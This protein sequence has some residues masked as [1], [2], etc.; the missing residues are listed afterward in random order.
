MW[1]WCDN[2]A[3]KD[4]YC[5]KRTNQAVIYSYFIHGNFSFLQKEHCDN[6]GRLA[7]NKA[8]EYLKFKWFIAPFF[9]LYL[10]TYAIFKWVWLFTIALLQRRGVGLL[11]CGCRCE[12]QWKNSTLC[13]GLTVWLWA[14]TWKMHPS[15]FHPPDYIT[16]PKESIWP[17][18]VSLLCQILVTPK[19]ALRGF[20]AA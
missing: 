9:H 7:A 11:I 2:C 10:Q 12:A 20:S 19:K 16:D 6:N 8:L 1:S 14:N 15:F 3:K 5:T 4:S 17:P 13:H 18:W